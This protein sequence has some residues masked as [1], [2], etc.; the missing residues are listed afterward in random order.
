MMGLL[1]VAYTLMSAMVG[2]TIGKGRFYLFRCQSGR[3]FRRARYGTWAEKLFAGLSTVGF[4]LLT[5]IPLA[6]VIAKLADDR[7]E[8]PYFFSAILIAVIAICY[9]QLILGI[10]YRCENDYQYRTAQRFV[11]PCRLKGGKKLVDIEEL[12]MAVE[13]ARKTMSHYVA[14]EP[15]A[16]LDIIDPSIPAEL[17]RAKHSVSQRSRIEASRRHR[18]WGIVRPVSQRMVIGNLAL[19]GEKLPTAEPEPK[20][21]VALPIINL[22]PT[23]EEQLNLQLAALPSEDRELVE[24]LFTREPVIRRLILAPNC[25]VRLSIVPATETAP[26]RVQISGIVLHGRVN[27]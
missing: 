11:V 10:A 1:L 13:R 27:P 6:E 23:L 8:G 19:D 18:G 16:E 12:L 3:E 15:G 17:K 21:E 25:R 22:K 20:V 2:A 5:L 7:T 4:S 24:Q 26:R 14:I 9:Y